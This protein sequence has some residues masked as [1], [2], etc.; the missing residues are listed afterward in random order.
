MMMAVFCNSLDVKAFCY[1][2]HLVL[3]CMGAGLMEAGSQT[4]AHVGALTVRVRNIYPR[5]TFIL[6]TGMLAKSLSF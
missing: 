2:R 4:G 6:H 3:D 5:V 1:T